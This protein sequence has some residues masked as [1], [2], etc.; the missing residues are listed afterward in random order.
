MGK[1]REPFIPRENNIVILQESYVDALGSMLVYAP[2]DM[3][4]M[5]LVMRGEDTSLLPVLPSGFSISWDG[6]S[7]VPEGKSEGS[8]VTLMFQLL[9]C[10]PSRMRMVDI[11][12]VGS[13]NTLVTSTVE[14][15]KA[16]LNC[17]NFK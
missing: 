2:F 15:I 1:F 16:A 5:T 9:A 4:L 14:K 12:F 3:E 8:L 7:D 17:S 13:V 10:S 6:Q 11:D